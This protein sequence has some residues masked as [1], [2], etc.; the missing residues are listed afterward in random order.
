MKLY[1][2]IGYKLFKETEDGNIHMIRIVNVRKPYNTNS[3]VKDPA[4]ITIFDY[5]DDTRKKVR[6]DSLKEYSPLKP[7]GIATF[8]VATIR[9]SN[10]KPCKDVLVTA[11][12]FLNLELK[13]SSIPYVVCRQN[14]TDIFY[15]YITS[16]ENHNMVGLS[17]NQDTCPSNFDYRMMLAADSVEHSEFINFYRLDTLDDILSMVKIN[18]YDTVLNDLYNR[19]VK[20][21]N[22]P[23]LMFKSEHN[24]WCKDLKTLLET[25]N[26]M[27]DVNQMLGI[28]QVD[29]KVPDFL[30]DV[31]KDDEITYQ[32]A[33]YDLRVWLSSTYSVNM[34]EIAVMEFGHDINLADF[35]DN[36]YLL[37]RDSENKLYLMVYTTDG[38]FFGSDLEEAAN[39][40][41]FSTKFKL[42]FFEKKYKNEI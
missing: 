39:Q 27:A 26:F 37:V 9:D 7:D 1:N 19:H 25:N 41:D 18:N 2:M 10:N 30:E 4:E 28:T 35:N 3:V 16:E 33:N 34:K 24:G 29:F 6:V 20:H 17:V 36:K 31:K 22:K 11:I 14:I 8:S 38:E 23:E 15:T 40:M 21:E 12:K 32:V 13:L 42:A 5:A